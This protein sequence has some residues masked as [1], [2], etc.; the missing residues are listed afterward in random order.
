MPSRGMLNAPCYQ[1][2]TLA[3]GQ[4]RVTSCLT[5]AFSE[6]TQRSRAPV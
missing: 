1:G 3:Q 6:D 5:A 2:P 4:T